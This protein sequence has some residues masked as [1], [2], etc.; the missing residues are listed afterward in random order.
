MT[1]STPAAAAV[2]NIERALLRAAQ[3]ADRRAQ[4]ELVRRYEPLVQATLRRMRL[5]A[6]SDR[7][8]LAQEARV[9]LYNAI[10]AWRPGQGAFPALARRCIVNHLIMTLNYAGRKQRLLDHALM[11]NDSLA[12]REGLPSRMADPERCALVNAEL[13]A[14]IDALPKLSAY[15]RSALQGA[16][17]GRSQKRLAAERRTTPKAIHCSEARARRKLASNPIF[18]AA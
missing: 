14:I 13:G 5:P 15:E 1:T 11:P 17:N 16:L 9:G 8:D 18:A 4:N 10:R 2:S 3:N 6:S 7:D 12:L